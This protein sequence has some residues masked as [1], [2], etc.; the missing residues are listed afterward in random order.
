MKVHFQ[1]EAWINDYAVEV[2][3]EGPDTWK[4][5]TEMAERILDAINDGSDLDFVR[6]ED[7]NA[8]EWIRQWAGPFTITISEDFR[9]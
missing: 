9:D 8:P 2:D 6:D 3:D 4:V 5:S 7:P 1:P